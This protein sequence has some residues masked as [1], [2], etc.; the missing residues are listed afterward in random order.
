MRLNLRAKKTLNEILHKLENETFDENDIIELFRYLRPHF[1]KH[2]LIW[3]I[4]CF[5]CHTEERD[6]GIIQKEMDFIYSIIVYGS[7]LKTSSSKKLNIFKIEKNIYNI[8]FIFGIEKITSDELRKRSGL[9]KKDALNILKK[10][11]YLEDKD[12][13][14]KTEYFGDKDLYN[15][16][17][18]ITGTLYPRPIINNTT[19][20]KQIE[21]SLHE[22]NIFLA[23]NFNIKEIIRKNKTDLLTCIVCLLHSHEFILFDQK[24]CSCYLD[25]S[26]NYEDKKTANLKWELHLMAKI[27]FGT[28][29]GI[30]WPLMKIK[31][32]IINKI[33]ELQNYKI[34]NYRNVELSAFNALRNKE[35]ILTIQ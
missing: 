7:I 5:I 28:G 13:K 31:E 29:N 14:M 20:L 34:E 9:S 33:P 10:A 32:K 23:T 18:C 25:L 30:I 3:E 2:N 8:L 12:Y 19:L 21:N 22:V 35:N 24:I 27:N 1:K 6:K 4:A 15:V 16:I 26:D 11:Y 17:N